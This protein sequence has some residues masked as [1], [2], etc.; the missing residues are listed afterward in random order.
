ME[1]S[2][3]ITLKQPTEPYIKIKFIDNDV[4]KYYPSLRKNVLLKI[5]DNYTKRFRKP[6]I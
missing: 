1:T 2:L 3:S 4:N 5:P 6:K